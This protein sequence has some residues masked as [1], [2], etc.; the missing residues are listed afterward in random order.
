M[1]RERCDFAMLS[2]EMSMAMP[3]NV[4]KQAKINW[5]VFC[6]GMRITLTFFRG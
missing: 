6:I 1:A 3:S 4:A 2:R 5:I